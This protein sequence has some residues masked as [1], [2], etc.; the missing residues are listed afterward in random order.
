MRATHSCTAC[1]YQAAAF[2][3]EN[4]DRPRMHSSLPDGP[5]GLSVPRRCGAVCLKFRLGALFQAGQRNLNM[6][7]T[8]QKFRFCRSLRLVGRTAPTVSPFA[9]FHNRAHLQLAAQRDSFPQSDSLMRLFCGHCGESGHIN[10]V[11][12]LPLVSTGVQAS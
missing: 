7:T 10:V 3:A 8:N 9:S 6:R 12:R 11:E 5:G 4:T 1:P 2:T